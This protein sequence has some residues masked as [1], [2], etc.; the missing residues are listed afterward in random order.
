[1]RIPGSS[2]SGQMREESTASPRVQENFPDWKNQTIFPTSD[3]E[4][5]LQ[6][7]YSGCPL[8]QCFLVR[9]IHCFSGSKA[10]ELHFRKEIW[11]LKR[12][13]AADESEDKTCLCSG[14]AY[15]TEEVCLETGMFLPRMEYNSSGGSW[16]SFPFFR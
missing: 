16:Y 15:K 8:T 3:S 14:F 10:M 9:Q 2:L 4:R 7:L 13:D 5:R 1:M 12:E 11:K 6:Y